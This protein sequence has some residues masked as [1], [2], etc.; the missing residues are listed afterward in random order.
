MWFIDFGEGSPRLQRGCSSRSPGDYGYRRN[1]SFNR[2]N[3]KVL[4]V[5]LASKKVVYL[6][7]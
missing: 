1:I 7:S 3:L 4:F 6:S 2:R 5:G